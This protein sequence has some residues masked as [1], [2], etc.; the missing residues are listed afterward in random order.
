MSKQPPTAPTTSAVGPCPTQIQF[1][2]TPGTGGLPSIIAPHDR[3][4]PTHTHK[5]T[6]LRITE[7]LD[8]IFT[9]MLL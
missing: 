8:I 4:P 1:G 5:R 7:N 2:R 3:P 9:L 6:H